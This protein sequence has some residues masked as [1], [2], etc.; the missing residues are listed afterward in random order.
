ML[1][2]LIEW[3]V[4]KSDSIARERVLAER[5]AEQNKRASNST[6]STPAVQDKRD[7]KQ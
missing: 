5:Q 6:A 3:W 2:R 4:R 1:S 7:V